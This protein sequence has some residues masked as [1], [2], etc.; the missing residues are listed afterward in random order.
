MNEYDRRF[1]LTMDC[2]SRAISRKKFV[3]APT[4]IKKTEFS[5][6]L[7]KLD[8]ACLGIAA[9]LGAG[10]YIL[11][12]PLARNIVGPGLVISFGVAAVASLL[13]GLCYAEFAAR[14]PRVGSA[15]TFSYITIGEM[16][17][18][19]IGWT[20]VL[21]YV[22]GAASAARALSSYLDYALFN[23]A[24]RNL[25]ISSVMNHGTHKVISN[26]PD[27]LAFLLTLLTTVAL[28]LGVKLTSVANNV[29]TAINIAV[30]LFIIIAGATFAESKNWADFL[31][32]GYSGVLA[33]SASAFY[34]FIGFDV[35]VISVEESKN[36]ATD[37]PI[38]TVFTIGK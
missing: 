9:T 15:Y 31:P 25:I 18:F 34:A 11:I 3:D 5:R 24:V 30:I 22:I 23:D 19:I 20:L 36:P 12:G 21:E 27:F 4:S 17:A 14:V 38:A 16:C 26:Y 33:A 13:S 7:S 2:L 1:H 32:F 6:C 28:C 35:I 29:V 37:V 10:I 8:L